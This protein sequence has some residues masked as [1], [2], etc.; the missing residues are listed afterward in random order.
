VAPGATVNVFADSPEGFSCHIQVGFE[1]AATVVAN[2]SRLT[3][4]LADA[5]FKHREREVST[6]AAAGPACPEHGKA[7]KSQHG[8]GYFCQVK[9]PDGSYGRWR[10]E[11]SP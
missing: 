4:A 8:G 3:R 10:H 5:G 6:P 11:A 1:S 2:L 9:M 7:K